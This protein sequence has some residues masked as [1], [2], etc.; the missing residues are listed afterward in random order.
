M[1]IR[2]ILAREE[3]PPLLV[4]IIQMAHALGLS[5]IAEGI[6]TPEQALA[7]AAMGC[8]EAQGFLFSKPLP[9]QELQAWAKE[10]MCREEA[11]A[12]QSA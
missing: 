11:R 3:R 5:V 8:E 4:S 6:E 10:R 2:G 12:F 1:F 7:L 9:F